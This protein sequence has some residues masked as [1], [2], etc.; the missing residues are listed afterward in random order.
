LLHYV[1]NN[2]SNVQSPT[3]IRDELVICG[4][5]DKIMPL[6]NLR[7]CIL[8]LLCAGDLQGQS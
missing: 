6:S 7:P 1:L 4:Y 5:S 8:V 2:F 3:T